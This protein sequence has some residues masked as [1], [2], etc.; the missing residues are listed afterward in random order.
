MRLADVPMTTPMLAL[1]VEESDWNAL[2]ASDAC[3]I[4]LLLLS[5]RR[6]EETIL[7][8]DKLRLVHGPAHSSIGQE[9]GAAGCIAALPQ[10]AR[11]NGT[12][13]AH[14]QCVAKLIHA[15]CELSFDAVRANALP[16]AAYRELRLMMADI[17]GL[18]EGWTGGR[19]GSMH[20]RNDRLGIMGTNAIVAGGLPQACGLAF[21]E[22]TRGGG[23]VTVSFFGDGAIHQ[24]AAHEALNL[25]ALY[26]LPLLFF[27]ENNNYAV[28]MSVEQ[29]TRETN[30]LT[31]AIAEGVPA[32]RVDGMNPLAVWLATR[33]AYERIDAGEGP[34]F[35]Q[36]DVYRY[37]HQSRPL[38][39]SAFGYR[40]KEE[41]ARWRERDPL[42]TFVRELVGRNILRDAEIQSVDRL[43]SDA[44][45]QAYDYIVE[46][47]GSASRIRPSLWP[48]AL[49]V[50]RGLT[51]DL[52]EFA[53][54][55][56]AELDAFSPE[57][58]TEMSLIEAMPRVV[59][60]R[61]RENPN[62]YVFGED[63]ANMNGGTVGA[64]KGLAAEFPGRIVNTPIAEN[65]F[66]GMAIGAA[67]L[68]LKPIV[69][70]MYSDF[71]LVAGD[72]L[73]NQAAKMRHL[74]GG[75]QP[76]SIVLRCRVP[77]M[78]GYGEQHSM[79]PAGLFALYPGWRIVAP[80]NAFDYVGLMNAALRCEDPVVV[81][82]HQGL[83]H[84]KAAV[85]SSLDHF[86]PIG[87]ARKLRE[88]RSLTILTTL[89]MVEICC[90]AVDT[91]E[92]SAD[93]I[94]LR[95]LSQRDLDYE[96]IEASVR[97]THNVA[98]VEQTTRGTSIGALL[99]DEIQRRCFDDLDQ[100]VKRVTGLW[101]PPTV[102]KPLERAA[103]A[104]R[105]EV[106]AAIREMLADVGGE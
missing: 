37:F 30:L 54:V 74:F 92:V 68:G 49:D 29:S 66:C 33:W 45:Q 103:L 81:I 6:F 102:S 12:H 90:E 23:G 84:R 69:E 99:S 35:V 60:A 5:A 28:S 8:L 48:E 58:M 61:M 43:V 72:Q 95:T 21:A 10:S 2:S 87:K 25:A 52:R 101:A 55:R 85:P 77:G 42:D 18:K 70:F 15:T 98:I 44:I 76:A 4:L 14:H 26:D 31:R 97:K 17:L 104:G 78:A 3:R 50:D 22:K 53:G 106:E 63:V 75:E 36:A 51:G 83:Y 9:G 32:V 24:G 41:E 96:M 94:D 89:A 7:R 62:I 65:G 86:V 34:A 39:G 56:F 57:E 47:E 100:P 91:L 88:G 93:V 11:M 38:P 1:E 82:E 59:G 80:S 16:D 13:R 27:L 71:A 64:T 73:F 40:T 19:G 79:D 46:G 20:L 67:V 105:E